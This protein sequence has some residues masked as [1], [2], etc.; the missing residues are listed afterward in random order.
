MRPDERINSIQLALQNQL[1]GALAG[2]WTAMPGIVQS[3]NAEKQTCEVQ[4]AV[5][6]NVQ[7]LK[8]GKVAPTAISLLVDVPVSWPSGGDWAMTFPLGQ[9]DEGV[10]IFADRCIDNWWQN[11][12]VQTQAESR[13]HD[14]SDG[15]FV[16]GL[17]SVP[18]VLKNVSTDQ[19]EIRKGDGDIKLAGTDTGFKITGTLE[20]TGLTTL[21]QNVQLGG[22]I[23]DKDGGTYSGTIHTT[24]QVMGD[25]GVSSGNISLGTHKHTGIQPGSGTSGGPTP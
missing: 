23:V 14:L 1:R 7:D 21:D 10:V 9:G 4:V 24:G 19:M 18:R 20:V 13:L 2:T 25:S 22:N 17:R 6:A 15:M 5:K 16:P 12:G 8:T 11:G 3:Y